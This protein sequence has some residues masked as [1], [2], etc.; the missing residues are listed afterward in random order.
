VYNAIAQTGE[1]DFVTGFQVFGLA[2]E[3]VGYSQ[4]NVD[5]MTPEIIEIVD[6]YAAQIVG[7]EIEVPEDP[8]Q[9]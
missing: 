7:G 2:D 4:S 5:L 3:G 6:G 9:A 8:A 1:G